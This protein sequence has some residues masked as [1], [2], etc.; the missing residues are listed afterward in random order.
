VKRIEGLGRGERVARGMQGGGR[1]VG[2]K[3][4]V[5]N[6][7]EMYGYGMGK[8]FDLGRNVERDAKI[9]IVGFCGISFLFGR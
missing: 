6:K 8:I 2:E 3:W 5:G 7:D 1:E 4:D 9:K